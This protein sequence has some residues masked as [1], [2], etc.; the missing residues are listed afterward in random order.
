[1][2]T[3]SDNYWKMKDLLASKKSLAFCVNKILQAASSGRNDTDDDND[4]LFVAIMM[5]IL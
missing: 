3:N 1:M 4:A 2:Q 5:F